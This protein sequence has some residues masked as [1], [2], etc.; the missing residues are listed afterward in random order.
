MPSVKQPESYYGK[1]LVIFKCG[2]M[3]KKTLDP[4][5]L[6]KFSCPTAAP[7]PLKSGLTCT[8]SIYTA[9]RLMELTSNSEHSDSKPNHYHQAIAAQKNGN[10]P[11]KVTIFP[12]ALKYTYNVLRK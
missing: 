3:T 11:F 10:F 6:S 4:A 2:Q 7:R 9:E 1:N 5:S 8:M 12:V